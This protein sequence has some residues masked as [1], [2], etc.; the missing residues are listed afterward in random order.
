MAPPEYQALHPMGIAPVVDIDGT[1]LAE[2]GAIIEYIVQRLAGGRLEPQPGDDSNLDWL[3]WFH[4]ANG[5]LMPSEGAVSLMRTRLS[6]MHVG[7]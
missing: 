3:F 1:M 6:P 2:R 7:L 5:T 4:F